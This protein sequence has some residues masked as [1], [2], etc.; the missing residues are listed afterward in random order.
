MALD[1]LKRGF[2]TPALFGREL[3]RKFHTQFGRHSYNVDGVDIFEEEWDNLL[4]LDSCRYDMF[5]EQAA[6]MFNGRLEQRIS[7]GSS[8]A[9]WIVGNIQ[10]RE[11]HDTVY[12]T[13]NPQ[14]SVKYATQSDFHAVRELW[15]VD[16]W[17]EDLHTV[18]AEVMTEAIVEAADEYPNKRILGHYV[19]PHYPFLG[20]TAEKHMTKQGFAIWSDIIAGEIEINDNILWSAFQETLDVALPAVSDAVKRIEGKTVV[21]ADHGQMI[22]ERAAPIPIREYGHPRNIHTPELLKVPWFICEFDER[23]TIHAEEPPQKQRGELDAD[24]KERLHDL[25]YR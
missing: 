4:V 9:E 20:P 13:G 2:K 14:Y 24:A 5:A 1:R 18:P 15:G 7:R 11:L 16:G 19:Q 3:N 12:V 10:N 8:T 6:G 23:R 22:G 21:T 25:G 17:D